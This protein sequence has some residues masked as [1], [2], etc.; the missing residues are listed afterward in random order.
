MGALKAAGVRGVAWWN[1]GS[2]A[3]GSTD[4]QAEEFWDALGAFT[5]PHAK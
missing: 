4:H 1:T 5:T 3:Y 2:V